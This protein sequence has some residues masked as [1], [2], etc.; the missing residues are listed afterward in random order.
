V[1]VT[2]WPTSSQRKLG[3]TEMAGPEGGSA[4][5][6]AWFFSSG[7]VPLALVVLALLGSVVIP[8]RQTWLITKLLRETTEILAPARL[9]LAQLQ[10]G[11]A[12]EIGTLQGYALAGDSASLERYQQVA[13]ENDRRLAALET[14]GGKFDAPFPAH[15][16]TVRRRVDE[17]RQYSARLVSPGRDG[18]TLA[19]EVHAAQARYDASLAAIASLS[20]DLSASAG[21]RDIRVRQ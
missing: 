3:P 10:S 2:E 18:E 8:A 9:L 19:A 12:E 6:Y 17:W 7:F 11:L 1:V 14:Q 16:E 13:A 15:L 21:S 4:L 20:S 5:R